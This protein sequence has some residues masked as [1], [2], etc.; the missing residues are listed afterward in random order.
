MTDPN[1]AQQTAQQRKKLAF[2]FQLIGL[3]D[4]ASGVGAVILGPWLLDD[5]AHGTAMMILGGILALAGAAMWWW[6]RFRFAPQGSD[7]GGGG[8]G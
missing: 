3:I 2:V 8:A 4:F 6:G 7:G 1:T 5:P